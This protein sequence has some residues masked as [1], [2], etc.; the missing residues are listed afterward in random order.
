VA[1]ATSYVAIALSQSDFD[2]I[3]FENKLYHGLVS[4]IKSQLALNPL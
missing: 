3:P 1:L 2:I 4:L